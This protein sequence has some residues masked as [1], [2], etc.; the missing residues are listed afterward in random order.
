MYFLVSYELIDR[1][2]LS[3]IQKMIAIYLARL[4]DEG[5]G[6]HVSEA[7]LASMMKLSVDEVKLNLQVLISKGL[8]EKN[9]LENNGSS[10]FKKPVFKAFSGISDEIKAQIDSAFGFDISFKSASMLYLK[11]GENLDFLLD[12]I[13]GALSE[14]DPVEETFYRLQLKEF[15]EKR[16]ADFS[17]DDKMY[18]LKKEEKEVLTKP[19]IFDDIKNNGKEKEEIA[20]QIDIVEKRIKERASRLKLKSSDKELKNNSQKEDVSKKDKNLDS[21]DVKHSEPEEL[22]KILSESVKKEPLNNSVSNNDKIKLSP[23]DRMFLRASSVYR[24]TKNSNSDNDKKNIEL[25]KNIEI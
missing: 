6:S 18:A 12:V 9:N 23:K 5:G 24:K 7:D 2:D 13:S 1:N 25:G 14:E 16:K 22:L 19:E 17:N 21:L 3:L 8:I 11:S 10:G 4:L 15:K 20:A